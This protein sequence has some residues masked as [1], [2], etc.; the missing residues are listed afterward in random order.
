MSPQEVFRINVRCVDTNAN[1]RKDVVVKTNR[2]LYNIYFSEAIVDVSGTVILTKGDWYDIADLSHPDTAR[3]V[4]FCN[5]L[6]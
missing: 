1:A 5:H 6:F 4:D 3:L 2:P